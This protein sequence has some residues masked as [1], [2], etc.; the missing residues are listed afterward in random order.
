MSRKAKKR[1]FSRAFQRLD[2][3]SQSLAL[4]NVKADMLMADDGLTYTQAAEEGRIYEYQ[5][6]A[7]EKLKIEA[8]EFLRI[9]AEKRLQ[10]AERSSKAVHAYVPGVSSMVARKGSACWNGLM[11]SKD[12]SLT[13]GMTVPG[14]GKRDKSKKRKGK[15]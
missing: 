8:A 5:V 7:R 15:G 2:K 13:S 6:K 4:I 14:T 11:F 12:P 9:E 1:E 3:S 10:N